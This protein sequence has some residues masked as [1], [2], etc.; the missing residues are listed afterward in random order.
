LDG[1]NKYQAEGH[2]L[3]VTFPGDILIKPGLS[4]PT[5]HSFMLLTIVPLLGCKEG[6][7]F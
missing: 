5:S 2:G 4:I 3:Q 1:E 7:H 6:C